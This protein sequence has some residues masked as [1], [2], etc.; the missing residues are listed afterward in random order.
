[1]NKFKSV[2][3]RNNTFDEIKKL[4][5]ELLPKVQLS[6]AQTI[7]RITSIAKE[8]LNQKHRV[9]DGTEKK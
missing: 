2:S 1:V 8:T 3:V 4:S 7:D 5:I 6:N 9:S